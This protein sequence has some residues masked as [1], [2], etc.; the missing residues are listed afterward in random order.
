M[1][2]SA[3]LCTAAV[4]LCSSFARAEDPRLDA[5][6]ESDRKTVAALES[7]KISLNFNET[8]LEEVV[9]FLREVTQ[10]NFLV[11]KGVREKGDDATVTLKVDELRLADALGLILD[12]SE[13][14]FRLEDGVIMIVTKEETREDVYL[15]L[16]DVRDLLFHLRDFKAPEISL[17]PID[18]DGGTVGIETVEA[19]SGGSLEDPTLLVDLIKNHTCGTSW[20]DNPKCSVDIQN[21]ILIVVQTKDGHRQVASLVE[22]LR[23][24]K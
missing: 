24:Y 5:K 13:L 23:Q 12:M 10:L 15:E 2:A 18:G 1:K 4:L 17:A 22:K 3:W 19:D 20:N 9:S 7:L 11:S 6:S 21:G 8:P 14:S 16:Y